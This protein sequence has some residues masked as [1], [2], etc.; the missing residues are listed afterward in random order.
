MNSSIELWQ[1]IQA[2]HR[3]LA[4]S[5]SWSTADNRLLPPPK[6]VGGTPALDS[7]LSF[8]IPISTSRKCCPMSKAFWGTLIPF[9]L[10]R[11]DR[12]LPSLLLEPKITV[13]MDQVRGRKPYELAPISFFAESFF[14]I[15]YPGLLLATL[16][17]KEQSTKSAHLSR[18]AL[19][20]LD[21]AW[22]ISEILKLCLC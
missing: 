22:S 10:C 11:M 16:C 18:K 7:A 8:F 20:A 6:A 12:P 15:F 4:F 21:W 14:H 19:S 3:L 17:K 9:T 1:G 5:Q 2:L 13:V